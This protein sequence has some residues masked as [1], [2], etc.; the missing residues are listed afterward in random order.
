[1]DKIIQ[2]EMKCQPNGLIQKVSDDVMQYARIGGFVTSWV[3]G[4]RESETPASRTFYSSFPPPSEGVP[5]SLFYLFC[6]MLRNIAIFFSFLPV[7]AT[8][9]I[10]LPALSPSTSHML[11]RLSTKSCQPTPHHIKYERFLSYDTELC[12]ICPGSSLVNIL[13]NVYQS[14]CFT[15]S[16][17]F[18]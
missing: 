1:M 14:W 13:Y 9:G 6:K 16:L 10:P 4:D 2:K 12:L 11:Q 18:H 7:P 15:L 8:L 5:T 3:G 17:L